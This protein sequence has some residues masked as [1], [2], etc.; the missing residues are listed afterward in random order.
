MVSLSFLLT[1]F[2]LVSSVSHL[3]G[4]LSVTFVLLP[5]LISYFSPKSHYWDAQILICKSFLFSR[6]I[7][8]LGKLIYFVPKLGPLP[9]FH[10]LIFNYSFKISNYWFSPQNLL[11]KSASEWPH[12]PLGAKMQNPQ[13]IFWLFLVLTLW[14]NWL[15]IFFWRIVNHF[16]SPVTTTLILIIL[17]STSLLKQSFS[18]SSYFQPCHP[19]LFVV[20][21]VVWI[22]LKY[23]LN[24]SSSL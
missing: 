18:W 17:S 11:Q 3:G 13:N 21:V 5:L 8:S 14:K 9:D 19:F 1:F 12:R 23:K 16:F 24:H 6:C 15:T 22:F 2:H 20:N 4:F 10:T 7:H